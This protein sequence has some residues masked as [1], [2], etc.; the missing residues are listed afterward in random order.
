M[1]PETRQNFSSITL[2]AICVTIVVGP[3]LTFINQ[4]DAILAQS[5]FDWLNMSLTFVIPFCVSLFSSLSMSNSFDKQLHALGAEHQKAIQVE[6]NAAV[7]LRETGAR[8]G[9][10]I[11]ALKAEITTLQSEN[12]Q[13]SKKI[14]EKPTPVPKS[15]SPVVPISPK[16]VSP[17][18]APP[19]KIKNDKAVEAI[20][21]IRRNATTVNE[22]SR[23][24]VTFLAS[25]IARGQTVR[26]N[27]EASGF[28][29]ETTTNSIEDIN[30]IVV[31]IS[32]QIKHLRE[33]VALAQQPMQDLS[34]VVSKFDHAFDGAQESCG[35]IAG[36]ARQTKLLSVNAAVE[37]ANAGDAG[38][39]FMV[40]AHEVKLLAEQTDNSLQAIQQAMTDSGDFF[41]ELLKLLKG[42]YQ[43][44]EGNENTAAR[45]QSEVQDASERVQ[46]LMGQVIELSSCTST[47]VQPIQALVSGI[48][49]IK[50]NTEAAVIGSEKNIDL[51]NAVINEFNRAE[52]P[53]ER[54]RRVN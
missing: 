44:I 9:V 28:C 41:Q 38:R 34:A 29:A 20:H 16:L 5:G 33:D 50:T 22:T 11:N 40:V 36:L 1:H 43:I 51:C 48:E 30:T 25:L 26:Q 39:G 6:Q 45:C 18:A 27:I 8:L 17:A 12:G 31:A 35:R 19:P 47:Q 53:V 42:L 21:Q 14:R 10:Q 2:R 3:I 15:L 4:Q 32:D 13:L 37:A 24:R 52:P 7:D 54:A 49:D 23:E 46:A